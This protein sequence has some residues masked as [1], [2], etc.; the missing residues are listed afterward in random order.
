MRSP[1]RY[2][3]GVAVLGSSLVV[4]GSIANA[5]YEPR[6]DYPRYREEGRGQFVTRNLDRLRAD[7]DRAASNT[8]PFVSDFNGDRAR[9]GR[10]R[11]EVDEFQRGW[12]AGD[13]NPR[14]LQDAIVAVQRVLNE[15]RLS[16]R[17]RD[18]LAS[19]LNWMREFQD[20]HER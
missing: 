2:L 18:L 16:D 14:Q 5:Q 17:T 13:F 12:N 6:G 8:A 1:M 9:I 11:Q 20:R 3:L 7:L 4:S 19:D 10:A 15:N